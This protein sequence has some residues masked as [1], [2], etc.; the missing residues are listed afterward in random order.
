M[1]RSL[2]V[3]LAKYADS[4]SVAMHA[5]DWFGSPAYSLG[6]GDD[7]K[8][9]ASAVIKHSILPYVARGLVGAGIGTLIG[10][11]LPAITDAAGITT[12]ADPAQAAASTLRQQ[13]VNVDVPAAAPQH[14][15]MSMTD[16]PIVGTE[17]SD[18]FRTYAPAIGM[19]LGA[20]FGHASGRKE[21]FMHG[22]RDLRSSE[23]SA[24]PWYDRHAT[25]E[26]YIPWRTK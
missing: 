7:A 14:S 1:Q 19:S 20:A 12:Q 23:T 16:K 21:E 11:T 18:A 9:P 26:D 15:W 22:I 5:N 24:V 4:Q 25:S 10:A 3:T 2:L 13:G 6:A 8:L 17:S